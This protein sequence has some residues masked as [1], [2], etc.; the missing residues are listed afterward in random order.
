MG[1]TTVMTLYAEKDDIET[2][3]QVFKKYPEKN[4]SLV[5]FQNL[6]D[7]LDNLS[8]NHFDTVIITENRQSAAL[9]D[10]YRI[11]H[12][13][14]PEIPIVILAEN[15][16]D[17]AV[18]QVIFE[19]ADD[20]V[21]RMELEFRIVDRVVQYAIKT[22]KQK[23]QI[24]RLLFTIEQ[25]PASILIIDAA[26]VIDY[27]NSRFTEITGYNKNDIIAE[28]LYDNCS[29]GF[30]N[31]LFI[32]LTDCIAMKKAWS[33]EFQ[34]RKQNG[35]LYW[36]STSISPIK[37]TEGIIS[38]YVAIS[39]DITQKKQEEEA[40]RQS[41]ERFRTVVQNIN[42]Y[43]Y[44]A[45]YE[46]GVAV[47]TY[48]SPKCL[49]VTGYTEEELGMDR[50]LW[51][52]MVYNND[53]DHVTSFINHI[54]KKK[55]TVSIEHRIVRKDGVVRWVS[56]TCAVQL[57]EHGEIRRLHGFLQDITERKEFE[58][59][60]VN[61]E[62]MLRIRNEKVEKDLKL[63]QLIQR[64]FLPKK[65]PKISHLLSD[66]RYYPL[67]SV[68]GDF[69]SINLLNKN[70]LSVFIGD[71]AG[72]GVSAALF[73]SLIKS[74]TDRISKKYSQQPANYIAEL[75]KIL[76]D[77]MPSFFITAIYSLF[78]Y[79]PD[80]E[81]MTFTFS[82]G[83]HPYPVYFCAADNTYTI[84]K[85]SSTIVGM[86]EEVT[87]GTYSIELQRC[88]RIFLMTDGIPEAENELHE[89]IGFEDGLT[90]LFKR[91]FRNSLHDTLDTVIKELDTFRGSIPPDD[92]II[93][94][95]FE[96]T[97]T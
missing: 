30:G 96:V 60:L 22:K 78:Q 74:A 90:G 23:E 97:D 50:E 19:G 62:R 20:I 84:I 34:N 69:F 59:T 45:T 79:D 42:E 57:D 51:F 77:E 10:V 64:S 2:L 31:E 21:T 88:D 56:N 18:Q 46:N 55:S 4:Y 67:D 37:N 9:V 86:F 87:Y 17:S 44:S 28:N 7:A 93:L 66:Y 73:L 6:P 26:G 1:A 29:N 83:G 48:H 71:V 85:K 24:R 27:V 16:N 52:S 80:K 54:F 12:H 49:E 95:G 25:I 33:G 13:S 53:K 94:M 35:D 11:L 32:R 3:E 38:H 41:E 81:L 72:H 70:T 47:S 92:D 43:I 91:S 89:I 58:E 15:R 36:E 39:R 61:N 14:M 65:N 63:A 75:N 82:N 5:H 76:I 68:G 8:E 40:L